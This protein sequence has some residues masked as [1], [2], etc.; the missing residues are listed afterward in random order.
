LLDLKLAI[1]S[2]I[3]ATAGDH[4]AI[5]WTQDAHFKDIEGVNY[6]EKKP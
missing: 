4:D 1:D 6:V 5:L 2:I 3:L